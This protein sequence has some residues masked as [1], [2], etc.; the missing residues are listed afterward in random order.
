MLMCHPDVPVLLCDGVLYQLSIDKIQL[1]V[2]KTLFLY[3]QNLFIF[4]FKM[5]LHMLFTQ[6]RQSKQEVSLIICLAVSTQYRRVT[7]RQTNWETDVFRQYSPHT[8]CAVIFVS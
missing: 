1:T 5:S 8:H 6:E 2:R 4:V 7:D 3:G